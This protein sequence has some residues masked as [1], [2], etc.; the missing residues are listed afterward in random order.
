M[1]TVELLVGKPHQIIQR[2]PLGE[3]TEF[4]A[5]AGAYQRVEIAPVVGLTRRLLNLLHK[6]LLVQT[7]IGVLFEL[8]AD[9]PL[10]R[11]VVPKL[12]RQL[13]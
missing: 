1:Q 11:G 10:M 5:G 7:V 13:V 12:L 9:L 4:I 6:R 8:L 2:Q 3:F